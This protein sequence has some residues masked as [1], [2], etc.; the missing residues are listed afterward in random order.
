MYSAGGEYVVTLTVTDNLGATGT[1]SVTVTVDP[2]GQVSGDCNQDGRMDLAD[3]VCLSAH[4]F[5]GIPAV[6]P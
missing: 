1:A 3:S 5:R 4:L 2:G 6:L